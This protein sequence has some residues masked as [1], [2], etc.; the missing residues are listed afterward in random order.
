M[1]CFKAAEPEIQWKRGEDRGKKGRGE[2]R[3]GKK[4][5]SEGEEKKKEKLW[6]GEW[7]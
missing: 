3:G 2:G 6:R 5:G 7:S 4:T 1:T